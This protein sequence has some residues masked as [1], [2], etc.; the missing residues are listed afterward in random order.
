MFP[1]AGVGNVSPTGLPPA[2]AGMS[3]ISKNRDCVGRLRCIE[4]LEQQ[5]T[6]SN[7]S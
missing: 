6:V 4:H 3:F 7:L 2:S 1:A 5:A